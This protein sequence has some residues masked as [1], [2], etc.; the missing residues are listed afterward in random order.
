MGVLGVMDGYLISFLASGRLDSV[1][2]YIAGAD[3][4]ASDECA[5]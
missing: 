1:G 3:V 2:A 4:L 5:G